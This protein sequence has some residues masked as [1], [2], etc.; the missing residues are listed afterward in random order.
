MAATIASK[1]PCRGCSRVCSISIVATGAD[2][3]LAPRLLSWYDRHGR[4]DLPWK[5]DATPYRVWVSEVMLQQ[6]QVTTV[7]PYYRRFM[8]RFPALA[9]LAGAELDQVLSLWTGLGYYARARNLH[10]SAQLIQAQHGGEMPATLDGLQALPGIGRSTAAAIL[11]LS[12]GQRHAILDG[13]V[14][15][16]LSRVYALPGWPGQAA[17]GKRLWQLSEQVTPQARVAAYTQAIMDL[18]ASLCS[19]SRPACEQCPLALL[20]EAHW[21]GN[22]ADFPGKRP[23]KTLPVR[24]STFLI[25][26]DGPSVLLQQRPP[27]GLWGGLWGFPECSAGQD[28]QQ[29][30]RELLGLEVSHRHTG[31]VFRHSFSHFHLD[32]TPW[33]G[34]VT[35]LGGVVMDAPGRVWYNIGQSPPGGLAAPVV[36]LL[37]ALT[38]QRKQ[39]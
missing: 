21:A 23:K 31:A 13:N 20:C 1:R 12:R 27:T 29:W 11:V 5:Q 16:V 30:C 24:A 37:S 3:E 25:L 39:S 14:K 4:H 6:T 2:A 36:Q 17:V 9:A 38:P 35:A 26:H 19:R 18:G 7:L 15:R 10:H 33:Q 22:P 28:P 8:Q 32:I 34:S